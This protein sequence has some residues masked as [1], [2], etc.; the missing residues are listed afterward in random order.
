VGGGFGSAGK[1]MDSGWISHGLA[2]LGACAREAGFEVDLIDLRAL[3]D[4]EH[5][6]KEIQ[7]RKPDVVGLTMMS[8]DYNPVIRCI[9]IVK[10]VS[11][12]TITVIG[13][14]HP[15]VALA[16]VIDNPKIDHI[17]THEGEITFVE[18]L[19]ALERGEKPEH[20]LQGEKPDL[21][22][23]PFADRDLFLNEWRKAGYTDESP[24]I[25]LGN[26]QKPFVTVIA[27]RGC[28]YNCSF[29]QPA[30]KILFGGKVRRRSVANVIGE[31]KYLYDKY[32]FKSLLIH[33]DCLTEDRKWV[34]EFVEAYKANGF[35][36]PFY[37]QSRAD[38]IVKNPDMVKLMRSVGL[39][40]FFIGFESGNQRVLN[41]LRK[42]TTVEQNIEAG[43]F[44]HELGIK[45]WA[46]YMMG[47]PTETEAEVLDT[48]KMLKKIDPDYYSPAF[49]TPHPGSDLF[50]YCQ[51]NGLS[52]ITDH[53]S[54]RR[55]PTELK[56]KGHNY[57]FLRQALEESQ[58]RTF[59]NS[60]KRWLNNNVRRYASPRK[61]V[62]RLARTVGAGKS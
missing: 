43:R 23:M 53:D 52:L 5:F 13:G 59:A 57:A 36:Q 16:E 39:S 22:A 17:V 15:T 34:A 49:Y 18:L 44:C 29:C 6:G 9:E 56:I 19:K 14:A 41:F 3:K 2:I 10:E 60:T 47:L 12:T 30:E 31:L 48:V 8:V 37:C 35:T 46:N 40:G 55:N 4:W 1:G 20:V 32:H 54:Y 38:I 7:A 42:G 11:P 28:I 51:E 62:R 45:V 26:L 50:T 27:G 25:P 58:R 24:E 61:V 33:D 21:D